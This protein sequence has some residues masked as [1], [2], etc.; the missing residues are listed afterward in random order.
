MRAPLAIA[1]SMLALAAGA[2]HAA[3][4]RDSTV[5]KA[6]IA[7]VSREVAEWHDL[8][9][10]DCPSGG[11]AGARIVEQRAGGAIEH[12][13]VA[14]CAGRRFLYRVDVFPRGDGRVSAAVSDL[15][16]AQ[17][18]PPATASD[19]ALAARCKA[20]REQLRALGD[21]AALGEAD[22]A[23]HHQLLADLML[24]GAEQSGGE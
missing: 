1:V 12:W 14:A 7:A 13:S 24:C 10:P 20:M 2:A 18:E 11:I 21:P 9:H 6:Q 23:R 19:K 17:G 5:P 4:V 16:G 15:D 3:G 22:I 8:R